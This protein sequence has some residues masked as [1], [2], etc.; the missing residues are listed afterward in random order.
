[1]RLEVYTGVPLTP[2]MT[3]KMVQITVEILGIIATAT[4]E[5]KRSAASESGLRLMS[6]ETDIVSEKFLKRVIGRTDLEDGMKKLDKLTN[7][8]VVMASA[9]LL[10]VTHN[11]DNKVTEVDENLLVVKDEVQLVNDNVKAIGDNVQTMA[12]GRQ[13]LFSAS[14]ASSLTSSPRWRGGRKGSEINRPTSSRRSKQREAFV[15]NLP[16]L[17]TELLTGPQG[18][19]YAKALGNGNLHQ[20]HPPITI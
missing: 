15:I 18:T 5:M 14:S 17:M 4:K 12:V 13:R 16:L 9:Q 3:D 1:M 7:E 20:I 11:I 10:K 19:N 2:A 8:E 6:R